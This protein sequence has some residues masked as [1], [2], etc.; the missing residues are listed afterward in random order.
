M[1]KLT[2]V[3]TDINA[4]EAAYP[5]VVDVVTTKKVNRQKLLPLV[6]ALRVLNMPIAG[7]NAYYSNEIKTESSHD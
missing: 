5:Q 2:I 1:K 3:I 4:L 7:V 6:K